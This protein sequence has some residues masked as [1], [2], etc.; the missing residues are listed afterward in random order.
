MI[1]WMK[2]LPYIAGLAAF[3]IIAGSIHHRGV[4]VG[5]A[6]IQAKF[7]AYVT[8]QD[9][10]VIKAYQ[11]ADA[12]E[13]AAKEVNA[14][15]L[16]DY[17]RQ[18]A[19]SHVYADFLASRLRDALAKASGSPVPEGT[20]QPGTAGPGPDAGHGDIEQAIGGALSECRDNSAQ[21]NALITELTPQL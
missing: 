8:A 9:A 17:Q 6:D 13:A 16:L 7:D 4:L 10:L 18:L 21:L 5:R 12:K 11:E 3:L 20:D 14:K 19:S 2:L 1:P 15:A